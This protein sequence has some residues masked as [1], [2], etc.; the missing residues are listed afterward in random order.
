M[1]IRRIFVFAHRWV[2]LLLAAFL[3]VEGATGSLLA[4]NVELTRLLDPRLFASPPTLDARRASLAELAERAEA[5]APQAQVA[6]FA[7]LRDDQAVLRM[8]PR[9][10]PGS[11]HPPELGFRYLVLD[12]Y[13]KEELGRL[14]EHGYTEGFVANLMPFV[15]DLHVSLALHD[16]GVWILSI[17]ALLWTVDCFVGFYLTLPVAT[18]R[19][20]RCWKLAWLVKWR[21]GAY[22]V[23]FDLHRAGGLW[24]WAMLFVFAWSSVA[25]TGK[26][27]AYDWVTSALFEYRTPIEENST[28]FPS[29]RGDDALALDWRAAE[30]RGRELVAEQASSRGFAI[31]GSLGLTRFD[32]SRL[33][34]YYVQTDRVFPDDKIVTVLFDGDTG[35]FRA[36]MGTTSPYTGNTITNWLRALHLIADP[37]D[38][39]AYRIFVVVIGLVVVMLSITG[40]CLWWTKDSARR[41][42][43]RRTLGPDSNDSYI[44]R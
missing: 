6:Y 9:A 14:G 12:P 44:D 43:A 17:V 16:T 41:F 7:R 20:W 37:V 5:L 24:L 35:A 13:S 10:T 29:R 23:T 38:Y 36:A 30:A 25:L 3:I 40:V 18:S 2:G 26:T 19:F 8:A 39:L 28:L 15:Y 31:L 1:M 21:A 42:H 4:F 33:Y 27:G 32:D 22:R 34:D 11:T